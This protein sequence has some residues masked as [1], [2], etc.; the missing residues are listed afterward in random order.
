MRV[1]KKEKTEKGYTEAI[2]TDKIR[3]YDNDPYFLKKDAEAKEA[4]SKMD[5]SIIKNKSAK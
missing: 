2:V 5:L 3:N 1:P 4:L